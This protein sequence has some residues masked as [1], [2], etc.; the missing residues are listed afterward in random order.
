VQRTK[1]DDRAVIVDLVTHFFDRDVRPLSPPAFLLTLNERDK[2]TGL[3]KDF[4]LV[5]RSSLLLRGLGG[6]LRAPL[7][8]GRSWERAAASYLSSVG[9]RERITEEEA[10]ALV[11]K[12]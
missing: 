12:R 1:H 10:A 2:V 8:C 3:P 4:M 6:K 7:Q 9:E 5:A 11:L